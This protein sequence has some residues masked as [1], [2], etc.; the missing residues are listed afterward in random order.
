MQ[1]AK[2]HL[3]S[4]RKTILTAQIIVVVVAIAMPFI[5][6]QYLNPALEKLIISSTEKEAERVAGHI[7]NVVFIDEI[8]HNYGLLDDFDN[9]PFQITIET[10]VY[11]YAAVEN[12]GLWKVKFFNHA[13]V[14][15][16]STIDDEIN[17]VI[18]KSYFHD[19]VA[20]GQT[21]TTTGYRETNIGALYLA[22]VYIPI[23]NTD[24][25]FVGAFELYYDIT[26]EKK[27]LDNL[28]ARIQ[29]I[30]V[31]LSVSG[32]VL[33]IVVGVVLS[34]LRAARTDYVHGLIDQASKDDLTGLLK[35]GSFERA[36]RLGIDRYTEYKIDHTLVMFDVDHFKQVN[37]VHGHQVGDDVLVG[38]SKLVSEM[39]RDT[40]VVGR[41]GGEEFIILLPNTNTN[42]G[43]ILAEKLRKAVE[44]TPFN[45][46]NGQ[47]NVTISLGVGGF[48]DVE[49]ITDKLTIS[50][51]ID[52]VD[53]A[54]YRSKQRGRNYVTYV[55]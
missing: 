32:V 18:Q 35:R 12:F 30:I 26:D 8:Y 22:E 50:T 25:A 15:N 45:T 27:Y 36:V 10:V 1:H 38:I 24:G 7:R 54:M 52:R 49:K 48:V 16:Y 9:D 20:Q 44:E 33:V 53:K 34:R 43:K 6:S 39:L 31:Y 47:L 21:Y 14:V 23:A 28:I 51:L 46:S 11:L 37:D 5:Q 19:V 55:S 41:Y 42:G 3:T 2:K 13:G 40:D 17:T 29:Q 4:L